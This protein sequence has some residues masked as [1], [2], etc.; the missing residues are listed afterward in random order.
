MPFPFLN[1]LKHRPGLRKIAANVTWLFSGKVVQMGVA[2]LVGIWLARYL[3]PEQFGLLGFATALCGLFSVIALLGFRGI[4]VRELV[5]T[6]E[7]KAN[8][9]GTT[10]AL[11][12]IGSL[13]AYGLVLAT[14]F[15]LRPD[16]TLSRII[17]AILGLRLLFMVT[18]VAEYWYE[19]QVESK[20]VV[21]IKNVFLLI[22]GAIKIGLIVWQAPLL[23]FVWVMMGE[24]AL[25][26]MALVLL[27]HKR[28]LPLTQL[29]VTKQRAK[30]LL[31]DSWPLFLSGVAVTIY[32]QIDKIMLGQLDSNQAVGIYTAATRISEAWYFI[33]MAI[34]ASVFPAILEAKK[35][36]EAKYLQRFQQLYSLM[37]WMALAV[38]IPMTF[39]SDW[40]IVLLFGQAYAQAGTVL[41]IH[42]WA[43]IFVFLG[44]ASGRWFL[45]E[46]LTKLSL[47]RTALGAITN[48]ILNFVLIPV[49]GAVGAAVATVISYAIV[50][51]FSDLL[52]SNTRFMFMMKIKSFNVFLALGMVKDAFKN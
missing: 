10:T 19:S 7:Q 36:G 21:W 40:L 14:V 30:Q 18:Q 1:T 17:V 49:Y 23:A 20:Y 25:T 44:V 11:Q 15:I 24:S 5:Q 4:V 29:T 47:E 2:L 34:V 43:S 16:D 41:A 45:A 28:I 46:N 38:A 12:L 50:A 51:M 39:L 27:F 8:I 35:Q 13:L 22:S 6:P 33:P 52:W 42:I 26:A 37:V 9:L 3:G 32:M 31:K 48:V